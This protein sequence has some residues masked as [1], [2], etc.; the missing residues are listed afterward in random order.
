M[1][2]F[3]AAR[4]TRFS[5]IIGDIDGLREIRYVITLDTDT[6]LPR[7]AARQLVATMEHPLN[8]P[9]F[10]AET[11]VSSS[12]GTASCSRASAARCRPKARR[13][14]RSC[15]AATPAS[16]HTRA[17]YPIRIR[18]CSAKARSSARASTTSMRSSACSAIAFLKTAS[19]ATI[20]SKDATRD[21][22][23][24]PTS[25][26]TSEY[27]QS[28]LV[29]AKRRQRWI[30]GDW[31]IAGG[32]S[33]RSR[34]VM[35]SAKRTRCR[36]CR[37]GRSSTICAAVWSRSH[38]VAAASC[39]IGCLGS[40]AFWTAVV[41]EILLLPPLVD[42]A[43]TAARPSPEST[44]LQHLSLIA[45]DAGRRFAQVLIAAA[46]LPFEAWLSVDAIARTYWRTARV[47]ASAAAVDCI[48]QRRTAR[49]PSPQRCGARHVD[50]SARGGC[51]GH[52]PDP[53]RRAFV[54]CGAL[55]RVV[56]VGTDSGVAAQRR[57]VRRLATVATGTD[58]VPAQCCAADMG[59]L[60][61]FR[62]RGRSLAAAGQL[63]GAPDRENRA[64]HVA[65]QHRPHL[66]AKLAAYD[67]GY[68]SLP[69]LIERTGR[70]VRDAARAGALSR[71][72]LQLV[73]HA[74]AAGAAAAVCV[75]SRQRQPDRAPDD[76]AP[77]TVSSC[78]R[79]QSSAMRSSPVF[80]IRWRCWASRDR[81][82]SRRTMRTR[83]ADALAEASAHR[84][85]TSPLRCMR[86]DAGWRAG[87]CGCQRAD[88]CP[89]E[90]VWRARIQRS[91]ERRYAEIVGHRACRGTE[92][93]Q[94]TGVQRA[95]SLPSLAD[96]VPRCRTFAANDAASTETSPGSTLASECI[97]AIEH[98]AALCARLRARGF[99]VPV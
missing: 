32:Y 85:P 74:H 17:R 46:C 77:G 52:D 45:R 3:A 6:Q 8:R 38:C 61:R 87:R 81:V 69:E 1:R 42:I 40:P 26:S 23:S 88:G 63:P 15:S 36:R 75:D 4:A 98:L 66:L 20:C 41:L 2:C 95:R 58:R 21:R 18:I 53:A 76:A 57:A 55:A 28:Y 10:D 90:R 84:L 51:R 62:R 70:D 99:R 71:P 86:T 31:Q 19:S 29:D 13:R 25:S 73:R 16:I 47:A 72:L 83:C 24:S 5:R 92:R 96:I 91:V 60:R 89:L 14:T 34:S 35:A 64:S 30:R 97:A 50:G 49:P 9:R 93:G 94:A 7:D 44:L 12:A 59:V 43:L 48:Q 11:S 67:F 37:I 68:L 33:P 22:A 65:D 78:R 27:P 80:P 39:W 54:V 82:R 56:D 79:A